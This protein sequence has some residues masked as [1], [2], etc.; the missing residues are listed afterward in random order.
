[1]H[2]SIQLVEEQ[3]LFHVLCLVCLLSQFLLEKYKDLAWA[4]NI[5]VFD[6]KGKPTNKTGELVCKTPF[7]S[8]P[9]YFWNDKRFKKYKS[10]YFEKFN[11][12]WAHGDYV[13][14]N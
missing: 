8:K 14:K 1:M 6:E 12:I 4:M 3:I 9:I 5:D 13:Q 7:P 2:L 10:A 11:N